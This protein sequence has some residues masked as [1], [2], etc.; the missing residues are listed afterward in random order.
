MTGERYPPIADYGLISD[1]HSSAL[2]SRHGSVDW[3]CFRRFEAPSTFARILDWDKGGFCSLAPVGSEPAGRRYLGP[4]M[5]LQSDHRAGGSVGRTRDCF[6]VSDTSATDEVQDVLPYH[7]LLR[8]AE[9][10][11]GHTAWEFVCRPRFEYGIVCPG[12]RLLG[13]RLALLI[14]GPDALSVSASVPLEVGEGEVRARFTLRKGERAW[15][16]LTRHVPERAEPEAMRDE[17]VTR[18]LDHTRRCGRTG[19]PTTARTA[20][21]CFAA[22]SR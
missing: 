16:V 11:A 21:R 19:A 12:A 22:R 13:D 1:C 5:I 2:V 4:T 15:F 3:A 8:V 9:G 6:A 17:E 7:Q 20:T 14:G 18:R 10:V